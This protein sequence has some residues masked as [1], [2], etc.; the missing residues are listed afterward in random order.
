MITA[1]HHSVE[2]TGYGR[3]SRRCGIFSNVKMGFCR[4]FQYRRETPRSK[5]SNM[6][7][8]NHR[9]YA[10]NLD[11][12]SRDD[13]ILWS[14]RTN[15]RVLGSISPVSLLKAAGR[16]EQIKASKNLPGTLHSGWNRAIKRWVGR[17]VFLVTVV[18]SLR[19][20]APC[21][22]DYKDHYGKKM[23]R[24]LRLRRQNEYT[25]KRIYFQD[26]TVDQESELHISKNHVEQERHSSIGDSIS[27]SKR[28]VELAHRKSSEIPG[29][30]GS[31]R[32]KNKTQEEETDEEQLKFLLS[33]DNSDSQDEAHLSGFR[34]QEQLDHDFHYEDGGDSPNVSED[35][36]SGASKAA[37]SQENSQVSTLKCQG[38]THASCFIY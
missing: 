1:P 35:D 15:R 20:L 27:K 33:L 26:G 28:P 32:L 18:L 13:K 6:R 3:Y 14:R 29:R 38:L 23:K 5:M 7:R 12:D 36:D 19:R 8:I 11:H 22:R 31:F 30:L 21:V 9:G 25:N 2:K 4:D 37:P 10:D 17:L 24:F 34:P 16:S